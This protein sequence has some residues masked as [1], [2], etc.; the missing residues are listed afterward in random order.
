VPDGLFEAAFAFCGLYMEVRQDPE[1]GAVANWLSEADAVMDE[2]IRAKEEPEEMDQLGDRDEMADVAI[3]DS[4]GNDEPSQEREPE[5]EETVSELGVSADVESPFEE[6]QLTSEPIELE[7]SV[8]PSVDEYAVHEGPPAPPVPDDMLTHE[9]STETF[10]TPAPFGDGED[11]GEGATAVSGVAETGPS[12]SAAARESQELSRLFFSAQQAVAA[13]D[14]T[15]AKLFTLRAA[16][17]IAKSEAAQAQERVRKNEGLIHQGQEAIEEARLAVRESEEAVA[18]KEHEVT[19]GR[20]RLDAKQHEQESLSEQLD[21]A[22][23]RVEKLD[24]EIRA[25]Q[26]RRDEEQSQVDAC[27]AAL[28]DKSVEVAA[29]ESELETL[30]SQEQEAR[31]ALEDAR[32]RV[33]DLMHR[34]STIEA[35]M[36]KARELM[37]YQHTSL[38]DIEQTISQI[39][40]HER[41]RGE[42]SDE[43]LF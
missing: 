17:M 14:P 4:I 19:E 22:R 18:A 13:G 23:G 40:S 1:S 11:V 9:A 33:K 26:A 5:R 43:L 21:V 29:S 35:E 41:D 25:L 39:Q 10:E 36:E 38:A 24:E 30:R 7:D 3:P 12:D 28:G 27:E 2:L 6:P 20:T 31:V 34:R 8:M 37:S 32:Q 16:A 42:A 15:Q